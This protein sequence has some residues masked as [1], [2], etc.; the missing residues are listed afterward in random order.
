V[1]A[2]GERR[3]S[4][5]DTTPAAVD[6]AL[7]DLV[8]ECHAAQP[9]L[10]L[11]RALNLVCV[12]DG[13]SG[14]AIANRLRGVG[15]YHGS[16]TIVCQLEP[17][18]SSLDAAVS[19]LT[20][21]PS[22][23]HGPAV[24]REKVHL[25]FGELRALPSIVGPLVVPDLT[26]VVWSPHGERVALNALLD[27]AEVVLYDAADEPEVYYAL[28]RASELAERAYVV[29]LA[30][31]RST[32]WRERTAALFDAPIRRSAS[33]AIQVVSVRH[34]PDSVPAALLLVGWL[35]SRLG[36]RP[37]L[38]QREGKS[39][40]GAVTGAEEKVRLR[41][42]PTQQEVRGLAGITIETRPGLQLSLD[43]AAGGLRVREQTRGC[44]E[45]SWTMMG[46]SRGEPGILG[47]GIR[48]A[49]LR[50]ST[51]RPALEFAR[52]MIVGLSP[53]VA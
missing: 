19:V 46:A 5:D 35:G 12:V 16:R 48:Q 26:T 33:E 44:V 18:R 10:A 22:G 27:I 31:L 6:A 15:R 52:E 36:W 47:E 20:D 51:Y 42:E 29:D 32:P 45:R 3:W 25:T 30:W 40:S 34:H 23:E 43:R 53:R 28:A 4:A 49:L 24:L 17:G 1:S 2:I 14:G 11:A 9:E 38:L 13:G 21:Y 7:R 50:D 8:V 41:L 39:L 37:G